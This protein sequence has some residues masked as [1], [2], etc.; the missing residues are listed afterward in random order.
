VRFV[1]LLVTTRCAISL[2]CETSS[3]TALLT[4]ERTIARKLVV[5]GVLNLGEVSSTLYRGAQPTQ[6][7]F[8]KLAEMGIGIVLDLR[9]RGREVERQQVIKLGMRL[10]AIPWYCFHTEDADGPISQI[11]PR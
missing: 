6:E 11:A 4:T 9:E 10:V 7:G 3:S 1:A 8:Q 2:A 5:P